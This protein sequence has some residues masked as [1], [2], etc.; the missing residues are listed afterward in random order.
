MSGSSKKPATDPT[1]PAK[2]PTSG[3]RKDA[4]ATIL[5]TILT[6]LS[7][8]GWSSIGASKAAGH[9][10]VRMAEE[11]TKIQLNRQEELTRLIQERLAGVGEKQP[12]VVQ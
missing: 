12:A 4:N 5:L 10:T 7:R 9:S 6:I 11:Y 3:C 1:F 8:V 2:N